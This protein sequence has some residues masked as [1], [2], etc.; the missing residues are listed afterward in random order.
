MSEN[1]PAPGL[2]ARARLLAAPTVDASVVRDLERITG[3]PAEQGFS[4]APPEEPFIC[5]GA[6]LPD[7][8]RGGP[9]VWFHSVNA[10]TDA[11]LSAG[12][13]PSGALLTRTVGRMGE[14]IAQYVLA[15]VLVG[16]QSV[17]EFAAQ[18]ERAEWRRIP[19]ELA[20]GQTAVIY[21]TGRIGSA[22][23]GLLG[24][25]GIRTVGVGRAART[26]STGFDRVVGADD[27]AQSLASA[28][29]VVSTLPLTPATDGFFGT[30]RFAGMGGA[31]FIN[32]GRGATVDMRALEAALHTGA[33]GRAVLDVLPE[34]PAEPGDRCWRLPRTVITSHSAGITADEDI[35]VDFAACWKAMAEGRMPD[36]AVDVGRGY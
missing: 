25:C 10:G 13:W 1:L 31:T 24:A 22:V 4:G 29:W 35:V 20:S 8:L 11:L 28:R 18:H 6:T 36:T 19:S 17:P 14:R 27:D 16:C 30:D 9:L 3:R 15:W 23:A 21:G 34:E 12:P 33:V 7:V 32:V 2:L 5:V 26:A